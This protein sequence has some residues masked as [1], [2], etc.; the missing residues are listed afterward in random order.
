MEA[1]FIRELA[2]CVL[3]R[4]HMLSAVS[5]IVAE[6]DWFGPTS[7]LQ[8]LLDCQISILSLAQS[9]VTYNLCRPFFIEERTIRIRNGFH[10]LQH[11]T[12]DQFI[13]NDTVVGATDEG[14]IQPA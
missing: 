12:V 9:A 8:P 13:P 6:L 5:S 4:K 3:R 1:S 10:L 14:F 11:Q 2:D 7:I